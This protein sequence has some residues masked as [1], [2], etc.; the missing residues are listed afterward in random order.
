VRPLEDSLRVAVARRLAIRAGMSAAGA[1]RDSGDRREWPY[2]AFLAPAPLLLRRIE[3]LAE[4][5]AD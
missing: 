1:R 2:F 4:H 5:A 3:G